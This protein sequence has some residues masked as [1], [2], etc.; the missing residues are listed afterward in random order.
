MLP[1]NHLETNEKVRATEANIFVQ[2][3]D[4]LFGI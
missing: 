4:I 3:N 2:W 1:S